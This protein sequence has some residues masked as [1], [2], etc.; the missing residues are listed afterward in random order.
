MHRKL[1]TQ[2]CRALKEAS[3][4]NNDMLFSQPPKW[5]FYFYFFLSWPVPKIYLVNL[6]FKQPFVKVCKYADIFG[7]ACISLSGV[8]HM[9]P[10]A[11]NYR[12]D[13]RYLLNE[14]SFH[15][16]IKVLE[17]LLKLIDCKEVK[18]VLLLSDWEKLLHNNVCN[19]SRVKYVNNTS[20]YM[21][22]ISLCSLT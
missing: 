7:E 21:C 12:S 9:N 1:K 4:A 16:Q 15:K 6:S 20:M 14:R 22:C 8:Y 19:I 3:V 5:M 17:I 18:E 2:S 10:S 13:W 11:S